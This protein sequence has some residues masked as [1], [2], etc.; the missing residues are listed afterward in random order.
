MPIPFSIAGRIEKNK[1]ANT[2]PWL[3]LVELALTS[4]LSVYLVMNNENITWNGIEWTAF[5]MKFEDK[6]QDMKSISTFGISVSNTDG[7]VQSYLEEYDGLA[8]HEVTIRLVH[9]AHL[10]NPTPEIEEVFEIQ[11]TSYTE[12]W[13][14]FTLGANFFLF[15]RACADRYLKDYCRHKYG[16]IECGVNT[17][18]LAQYSSCAHVLS[19]C[20]VRMK[21]SGINNIRFGGFPGMGS[22][23]ASNSST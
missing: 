19:E 12:S 18:C 20:R 10:D 8:D 5:P 1:L 3:L 2:K 22:V 4:D 14:T 16:K 23:F 13:V 17:A 11:E 21:A 6:T 15:F 9:A 7:V